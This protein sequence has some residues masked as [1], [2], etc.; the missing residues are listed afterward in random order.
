MKKLKKLIINFFVIV[1]QFIFA[2]LDLFR[3]YLPVYPGDL[4]PHL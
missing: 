4:F 1:S 3:T 2:F